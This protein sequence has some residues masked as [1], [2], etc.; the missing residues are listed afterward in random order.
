[1]IHLY[2]SECVFAMPAFQLLYFIMLSIEI[3]M[4]WPVSSFIPNGEQERKS[5]ISFLLLK[6]I[7]S[8]NMA[9]IV[10]ILFARICVTLSVCRP[11]LSAQMCQMRNGIGYSNEFLFGVC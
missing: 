8:R 7:I 6:C 1:M 11:A 10:P 9:G 2:E 3:I 4:A 5:I